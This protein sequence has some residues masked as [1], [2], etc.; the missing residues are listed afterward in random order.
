MQEAFAC[1]TPLPPAEAAI[2]ALDALLLAQ[3]T[4]P[5]RPAPL[6]R[7]FTVE[8]GGWP[9]HVGAR[10]VGG[11][12]AV[13]AEVAPPGAIDP[14]WLLHRNRRDLRLVRYGS[15]GAGAT[16]VHGELPAAG[17]TGD[18]IDELLARL[19][20]AAEAARAVAAWPGADPD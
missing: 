8:C 2:A 14:A 18:A 12:L 15:S 1:R 20:A 9:L 7:G 16:W 4:R 3:G 6:E 11:L 13:Q 19:I 5:H 10:I 17:S